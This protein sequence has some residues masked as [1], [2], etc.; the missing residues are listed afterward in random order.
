MVASC[1]SNVYHPVEVA[2]ELK[3]LQLGELKRATDNYN[4]NRVLGQGGFGTVY[5]GMLTDGS[6]VAVKRSKAVFKS[7]IEQFINEV[8]ILSQINHRN[9]VK[10]LGCCLETE[11]PVLVY[12]FIPNGT[13]SHHINK[14][15][16]YSFG[17]VL[18]ELVTGKTPISFARAKERNLVADFIELLKDNQLLEIL[19]PR[20]ATEARE[21]DIQ[22]IAE[23]AVRCLRL[24]RKK[25]PT[26]KEVV[27]ELEG[28][29]RSQSSLE[30][31]QEPQ[32]M[33]DEMLYM[34]TSEETQQGSI[35]DSSE[36]SLQLES[37]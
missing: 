15:D 3:Y 11:V 16:V 22:S 34:E 23:L 32:Q 17:V 30:I 21:E 12:E 31:D 35:E 26:M 14:S 25:R 9:I 6:I 27:T 36:F 1:C 10:L 7:Q 18:V 19:D 37:E 28:L 24:N 13:L 8:V 33:R 20:V 5:K 29:I 2:K 4:Q